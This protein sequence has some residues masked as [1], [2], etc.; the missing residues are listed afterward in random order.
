MKKTTL[1]IGMIIMATL[2]TGC[3]SASKNTNPSPAET[4]NLTSMQMLTAE[5]A[6]K[7]ISENN[8][9]ANLKFTADP[10]VLVYN[11]TVY[12][13]GTNDSQQADYTLGKEDNAYNRINTL[14]CYSSKDLVNWTYEAELPIAGRSNP[15][16]AA[17]WAN[18]CWAPAI[19]TKKI[20]GVD[21]FFLYFA[22]S[23]NGIGVVTSDSPTG[24]FV[25]PIGK[26]LVTRQTPNTTGVHWLFDPAV[27][28]DDDGKGYLYYGGGVA[29]DVPHPKSARCVALGDDMISIAC[30][31]VQ[32][33][34]PFLF[35]DSGI[36]KI[37]GKYVYSY[38]TNWADR[39]DFPGADVPPVANIAYMTSDNPLGPFEYQGC[40]LKN[41]G[42]YFGPWGNNHHWV[43]TFNNKY[44]V[45]YHAQTEEKKIGFEKGG[46][47]NVFI[48]ELQMNAD[49]SIPLQNNI[50]KSGVEQVGTFDA[51]TEVPGSTMH[52]SKFVVSTNERTAI[53]VKDGA[54]IYILGADLS[55]GAS[56][57]VVK[58]SENSQ[59][60]TF[61]LMADHFASG[62][63]IAKVELDGK[64]EFTTSISLPEDC[65]AVKNLYIVFNGTVEVESWKLNK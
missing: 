9:I 50:K 42:T 7:F 32:I 44:Y 23:A 63:E 11:N 10:A 8:P 38:C 59:K 16:G 22:D 56:S 57:I 13:Y 55:E 19:C 51:Y 26:G 35:E 18:N 17:K 25:D 3:A 41:P 14:N 64:G 20:N 49:G 29:D 27:L 6:T 21:K 62:T 46:Y 39:K 47:R 61:T 40:F 33:D 24:P 37:N 53:P 2:T 52:S 4:F 60:G 54:Y 36:N 43:F 30:E 34:P 15:K 28:V 12:I 31:P 58:T 1:I 48:N 5:K 45:A 65:K